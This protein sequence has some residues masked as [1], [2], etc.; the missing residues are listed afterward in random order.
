M[1]TSTSLVE[2]EMNTSTSSSG[3]EKENKEAKTGEE[4]ENETRFVQESGTDNLKR[5]EPKYKYLT[6]TCIGGGSVAVVYKRQFEPELTKK[7]E[8][9]VV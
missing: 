1:N 7:E 4:E 6:N 2:V 5:V 8:L 3:S 9:S